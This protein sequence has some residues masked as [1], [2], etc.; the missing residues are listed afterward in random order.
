MTSGI[1]LVALVAVVGASASATS[2]VKI[3]N[4]TSASSRPKMVTLTCGDGN[5]ALTGLR[6]SSF[7]GASALATG[8]LETNTCKPNCAAGKTVRYTVAVKASGTRTCKAGLRVYNKLTLRFTRRAPSAA[9]S[10]SH[11]TLG[12]PY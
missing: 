4:C 1:L 5:T 7:G 8:T 12:C 9:R 11:W 2:T 3:T 10:L 6:W